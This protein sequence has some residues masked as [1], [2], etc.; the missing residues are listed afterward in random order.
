VATA[1]PG[2]CSAGNPFYPAESAV[3]GLDGPK[4]LG[5][6]IMGRRRKEETQKGEDNIEYSFMH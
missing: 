3:T 1:A 2:F 4:G 6:V 5:D